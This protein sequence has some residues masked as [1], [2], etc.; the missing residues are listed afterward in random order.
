MCNHKNVNFLKY[1][2]V[3]SLGDSIPILK[4]VPEVSALVKIGLH[5]KEGKQRANN[6]IYHY[7]KREKL[8]HIQ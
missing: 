5:L 2:E 8:V 6:A 7:L 4:I 1:I 3:L